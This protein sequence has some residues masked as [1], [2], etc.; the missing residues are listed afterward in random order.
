MA[1]VSSTIKRGAKAATSHGE[2][3]VRSITV[4]SLLLSLSLTGFH[5]ISSAQC[6]KGT[7]DERE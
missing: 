4:G 7:D 3:S 5:R 6:Q 1:L 2:R